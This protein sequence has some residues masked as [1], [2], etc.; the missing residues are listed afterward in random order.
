MGRRLLP[1][2]A[3]LLGAC[4][5][6]SSSNDPAPAETAGTLQECP[7]H[8]L[9]AE[10]RRSGAL[11]AIVTLRHVDAQQPVLDALAGTTHTLLRRYAVTPLLALRVDEAA[12]CR[13]LA[14]PDVQSVSRDA[15]DP[16]G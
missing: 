14:H 8:P 2:V 10:A 3:L 5:P 1:A 15:A 7:P 9:R 4:A 12:L 16:P 11:R 13:L 6:R